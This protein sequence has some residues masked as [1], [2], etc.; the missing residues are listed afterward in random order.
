MAA[1][2]QRNDVGRIFLRRLG[3]FGLFVIFA[4]AKLAAEGKAFQ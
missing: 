1:V 4:A 3:L 2:R